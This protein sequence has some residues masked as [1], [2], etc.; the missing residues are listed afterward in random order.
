M[1][2]P[3]FVFG[4]LVAR[5]LGPSAS[6]ALSLYQVTER[7]CVQL[8]EGRINASTILV[9]LTPVLLAKHSARIA[10]L[11]LL[12]E[13]THNLVSKVLKQTIASAVVVPALR[14]SRRTGHPRCYSVSSK[15][16][17]ATRPVGYFHVKT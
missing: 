14:K 3:P 2:T 4:K 1:R 6:G 13:N 12:S 7:F 16:G 8:F 5:D 10:H 11:L 9:P 17:W 15:K